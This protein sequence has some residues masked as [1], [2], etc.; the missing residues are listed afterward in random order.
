M[1]QPTLPPLPTEPIKRL[2]WF[3]VFEGMA[4]S[5]DV[6]P[7]FFSMD[8][9]MAPGRFPQSVVDHYVNVDNDPPA[10]RHPVVE[11]AIDVSNDAN[12]ARTK[13]IHDRFTKDT[14]ATQSIV[15]L[16][17]N[18][19]TIPTDILDSLS[20]NGDNVMMV[21]GQVL[22]QRLYARYGTLTPASIPQVREQAMHMDKTLPIKVN[23]TRRDAALAALA[24]AGRA[25]PDAD[26]RDFLIQVLEHTSFKSTIDT[27]QQTTKDPVQQTYASLCAELIRAEESGRVNLTA[28]QVLH[29]T[30]MAATAAPTSDPAMAQIV[31]EMNDLKRMVTQFV[32][33]GNRAAGGGTVS[34]APRIPSER[35]PIPETAPVGFPKWCATHKWTSSHTTEECKKPGPLHAHRWGPIDLEKHLAAEFAA[36]KSGGSA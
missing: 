20:E 32:K 9:L 6:L 3:A 27:W 18:G 30:A 25:F 21:S 36:R 14:E 13:L 34:P 23:L 15:A 4:H 24:R 7:R 16:L 31:K 8:Q 12:R 26:K 33:G 17:R 1:A 10:L 2:Q 29:G 19:L 11:P 5:F 28:H 22:Y 35:K